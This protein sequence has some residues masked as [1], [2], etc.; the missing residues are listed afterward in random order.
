MLKFLHAA[1][2]HLDSP[3]RGLERYPGAPID[4]IRGTTRQAF[5]NLISLAIEEEVAFVLLAGDI[6]D[7][8]WKDYNT[9]SFYQPEVSRQN[10]CLL[11][12]AFLLAR[13][14][15]RLNYHTGAKK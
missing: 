7:G 6:Y 5:N 9:E 11:E 4:F 1:D 12:S 2:I 3:L 8:D 14:V 13:S 15:S 10:S